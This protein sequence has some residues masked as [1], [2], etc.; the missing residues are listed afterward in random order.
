[1]EPQHVYLEYDLFIENLSISSAAEAA[2]RW[3]SFLLSL[4]VGMTH[5]GFPGGSDGKELAL[6]C[7]R[8]GFNPWVRKISCRREWQPIPVFLPGEFN[9]Q[10]SL[11]GYCLWGHNESDVTEQQTHIP[12]DDNSEA[13]LELLKT[14]LLASCSDFY[15]LLFVCLSGSWEGKFTGSLLSL[16]PATLQSMSCM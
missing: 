12:Q 13:W 14:L 1:M 9:G 10:R 2:G 15:C 3:G 6:R 11:V 5:L 8:P 4:S 16:R 7:R